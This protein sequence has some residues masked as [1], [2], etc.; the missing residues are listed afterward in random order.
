MARRALFAPSLLHQAFSPHGITTSPTK[1]SPVCSLA[2]FLRHHAQQPDRSRYG[3]IG[4]PDIDR[5]YFGGAWLARNGTGKLSCRR[6]QHI[7]HADGAQAYG[8]STA[9]YAFRPRA[10]ANRCRPGRLAPP[11]T[12]TRFMPHASWRPAVREE[13]RG[14]FE[15][16]WQNAGEYPVL[17][18]VGNTAY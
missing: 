2:H 14:A 3:G 9:R 6:Y 15:L 18:L 12:T 7:H 1:Y 13:E 10:G 11:R 4:S 8:V 5:R 17:K 16:P